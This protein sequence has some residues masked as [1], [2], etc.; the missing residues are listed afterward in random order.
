MSPLKCEQ[1]LPLLDELA[2]GALG[3]RRSPAVR[4]HLAGCPDCR[5][6][7][8]LATS[9]FD[10][11]GVLAE[12]APSLPTGLGDGLAARL[13]SRLP[14]LPGEEDPLLGIGRPSL[15]QRLLTGTVLG[16]SAGTMVT[17]WLVTIWLLPSWVTQPVRLTAFTVWRAFA[18]TLGPVLYA[19]E[20][21]GQIAIRMVGGVSPVFLTSAALLA[22][23]AALAFAV[24]L[25]RSHREA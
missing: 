14:Q 15:R 17:F 23:L 19:L 21:T 8:S 24:S 2:L 22:A 9:L 6:A 7:F 1:V 12:A 3:S 18:A 16:V 5:E 10:D 13:L 25:S 4:E 20:L 11:L